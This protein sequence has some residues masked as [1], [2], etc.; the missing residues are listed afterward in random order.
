MPCHDTLV[1]QREMVMQTLSYDLEVQIERYTAPNTIETTLYDLI[2]AIS[3][4]V[5]PDNDE[6]VTA[7]LVHLLNSGA[8]KFSRDPRNIEVICPSHFPTSQQCVQ[9]AE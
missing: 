7:T 9:L 3:D 8:V 2:A 1:E 6:M 4:E 5:A